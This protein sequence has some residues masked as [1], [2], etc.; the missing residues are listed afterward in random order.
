[1]SDAMEVDAPA[2][3]AAAGPNL[4]D[5]PEPC[6]RWELK[7]NGTV[8]AHSWHNAAEAA[9]TY[10]VP[11]QAVLDLQR[12]KLL[13][14][15]KKEDA[16]CIA[17]ILPCLVEQSPTIAACAGSSQPFARYTTSLTTLSMLHDLRTLFGIVWY[18]RLPLRL[19][20]RRL[21]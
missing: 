16:I 11:P 17:T 1:M 15:E 20:S 21:T 7:P 6:P 2:A 19:V 12:N 18:Q 8:T 9:G 14:I 10:R 4:L 13:G 3:E 5:L